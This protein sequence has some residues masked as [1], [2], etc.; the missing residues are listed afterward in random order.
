[1]KN[2][3]QYTCR[4]CHAHLMP[5]WKNSNWFC[6]EC[7]LEQT[8]TAPVEESFITNWTLQK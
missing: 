3:K 7:K 6:T 2:E 1:M 5:L 4:S 8:P